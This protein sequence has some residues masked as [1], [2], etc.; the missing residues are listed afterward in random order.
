[1][2]FFKKYFPEKRS[3]K[4]RFFDEVR[5]GR[6]DE[7]RPGRNDE[8]RKTA[9]LDSGTKKKRGSPTGRTEATASVLPVGL[10]LFFLVV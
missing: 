6:N 2:A 4:N 8:V 5:P 1:M 3:S 10:P 9:F 7:V